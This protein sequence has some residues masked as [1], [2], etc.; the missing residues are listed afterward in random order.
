MGKLS[1]EVIFDLSRYHNTNENFVFKIV[2]RKES[3]NKHGNF[4]ISTL[5]FVL[6]EEVNID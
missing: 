3:Q 4:D 5:E 1:V 6:K 2:Y